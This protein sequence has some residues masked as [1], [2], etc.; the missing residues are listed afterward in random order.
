MG[1]KAA[2]LE[3]IYG[4]IAADL[5]LVEAELE[6]QIRALAE[7]HEKLVERHAYLKEIISSLSSMR[8]KLLRPALV[9]LSGRAV[10]GAGVSRSPGSPLV[11]MAVAAELVHAASLIHDDIIDHAIVRRA[12]AA[13]YREF[14]TSI[15]VLVGDVLYAQ[16]FSLI[17]DLQLPAAQR[18]KLVRLFCAV[19]K[20]MSQGEIFQ[21]GIKRYHLEI[22]VDDYLAIIRS[23]TAALMSACCASGALV[24]AASEPQVTA[25]AD[26]GHQF[27]LAFQLMDDQMDQDALPTDLALLQHA[28]EHAR[29]AGAALA[30]FPASVERCALESLSDFVLAQRA[31][32]VPVACARGLTIAPKP[33]PP[34]S[35]LA[36][37]RRS[38]RSP[39]ALPLTRPIRQTPTG[40][41]PRR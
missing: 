29:V 30:R 1:C 13:M 39:S 37:P 15:A 9:L 7:N 25:A 24:A 14:G 18:L 11:T 2:S 3:Q 27:G 8:G 36:Q 35:F 26:F 28:G 23:K 10:G 17:A 20:S 34:A 31:G 21:H 6:L 12:R 33:P 40:A 5:R 32:A 19:T 38:V 22:T 16:F 4:P 41:V